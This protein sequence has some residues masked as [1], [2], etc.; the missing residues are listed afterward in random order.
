MIADAA[1]PT[2]NRIAIGA[3]AAAEMFSFSERH[4]RQLDVE[5]KVPAP[6]RLG[7]SVRWDVAELQRWSAAGCPDRVEWE[8]AKETNP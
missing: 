4:W 1:A 5:G 2:D 7:R 3:A 6:R 8:S